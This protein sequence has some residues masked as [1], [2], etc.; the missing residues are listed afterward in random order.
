MKMNEI[1]ICLAKKSDLP[2]CA[3]I[4]REIYNN[5]VLNEG[6]TEKSSNAICEFYFKL[7]P[8]LF[9]VAKDG[10][11][12]LGFTFAFVKP[13][14]KGNQLMI[15]EISVKEEFRKQGIAKNLLKTLIS[16]AKKKYDITNVNGETYLG[17]G[18]MPYSWYERI[19]FKKV[20]ELFLIEGKTDEVLDKLK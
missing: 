8:D 5:N 4:L 20:D 18:G 12:I 9:F 3:G 7:Q 1:E 10:G 19:E 2:K 15:G 11:D 6:W 17:E 13:W 14:A 16:S